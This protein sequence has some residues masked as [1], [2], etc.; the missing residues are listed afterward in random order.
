MFY[1]YFKFALWL[2][3]Y[4]NILVMCDIVSVCVKK[5]QMLLTLYSVKQ[6]NSR[7]GVLVFIFLSLIGQYKLIVKTLCRWPQ[8][9]VLSGSISCDCLKRLSKM[10]SYQE[11]W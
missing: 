9:M 4:L 7:A 5:W 1:G 10:L 2:L 8:K 3:V 11:S 6:Y